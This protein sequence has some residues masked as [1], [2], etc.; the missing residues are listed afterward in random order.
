M[1]EIQIKDQ[2][3][4]GMAWRF[5]IILLFA[6]MVI[7]ILFIFDT[8]IWQAARDLVEPD[9]LY[10]PELFTHWGVY[11]FYLIFGAIL[12]YAFI[13]KN[14]KLVKIGLAYIKAQVVFSLVVV[15]LLKVLLGRARPGAEPLSFRKVQWV[16]V[17]SGP[18]APVHPVHQLPV[19]ISRRFRSAVSLR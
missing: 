13:K 18:P 14:R 10:L 15:R 1:S 4:N 3:K 12:S 16:Q 7:A 9:Y 5:I 17:P 2:K 8:P 19:L 11:L 6:L